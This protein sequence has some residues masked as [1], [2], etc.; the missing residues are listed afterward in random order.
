MF[1]EALEIAKENLR[2]IPASFKRHQDALRHD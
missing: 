2:E 1:Y